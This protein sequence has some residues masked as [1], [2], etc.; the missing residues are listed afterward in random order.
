MPK[1]IGRIMKRKPELAGVTAHTLRHSFASVADDLG[2]TVPTIAA[3][4]GHG[5]GTATEGYVHKLDPA[6]IA[7][8][9]RVGAL[10]EMAMAGKVKEAEI[11]DFPKT[12]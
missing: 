5:K 12:A 3:M 7:A 11:V 8:A 2:Y 4:L 9:D 6:L 10:I 1:A